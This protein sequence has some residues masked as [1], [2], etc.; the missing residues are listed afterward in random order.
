MSAVEDI[1]KQ[2]KGI[3]GDSFEE[4]SLAWSRRLG[5]PVRPQ[6]V[7]N[8]MADMKAVRLKHIEAKLDVC[9]D[10]IQRQELVKAKEDTILDMKA[11][12][13]IA[14]KFEWYKEL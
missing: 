13:T 4:M 1:I 14:D 7:A 9:K 12:S 3:Y 2:R 8:L 6:T 5:H 11:Y 10:N